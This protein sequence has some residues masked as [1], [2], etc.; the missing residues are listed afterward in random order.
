MARAP[1]DLARAV[2]LHELQRGYT[3][4]ALLGTIGVY[5]SITL[6]VQGVTGWLD[7]ASLGGWWGISLPWILLAAVVPQFF[8]LSRHFARASDVQRLPKSFW[9]Q[10]VLVLLWL[11]LLSWYS[12][13][14]LSAL[15]L[16]VLVGAVFNDVS[17]LFDARGLYAAYGLFW[18]IQVAILLVVDLC[19]GPGLLQRYA[20]N[21]V[22]VALTLAT[23]LCLMVLLSAIIRVVGKN[24]RE[25]EEGYRAAGRLQSELR[26]METERGVLARSCDFLLHGLSATRFSHDVASP[27]SVLK[28]TSHAV[29]SALDRLGGDEVV[30]LRRLMERMDAAIHRLEG[31]TRT[32]A[33][34][35]RQPGKLQ[36]ISAVELI[37]QAVAYARQA[38]EQH[39]LTSL[40]A[41]V[42]AS[43]AD[44]F[45]SAEHTSAL[46][47]IISNS[48]LEGSLA[49]SIKGEPIDDLFYQIQLRD[50]ALQGQ[51]RVLALQTI[52][53]SM[54]LDN[55][56]R[57]PEQ[58]R[59]TQY[60]GYGIGLLMT[61][62]LIVRSGG[63]LSVHAPADGPGICFSVILPR[64]DPGEI[65]IDRNHP[66]R[67]GLEAPSGLA[68]PFI[69]HLPSS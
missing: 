9:L 65:P 42:Q 34:S 12:T 18:P 44:V 41:T 23:E 46:A 25:K 31:M 55:S 39:Q 54:A 56:M 43:A 36:S 6:L 4:P 26:A 58:R 3:K 53:Q 35:L 22:R 67:L 20:E 10:Q 52:E 16:F 32:M 40:S 59:R 17:Y 66:E 27:L 2:K 69:S 11:A 28:V 45:V 50:W 14:A 62:V 24:Q 64:R 1:G 7:A 30:E 61:R 37:E 29:G 33:R 63:W 19:G 8:Q 47:S 5:V 21:D 51:E 68:A 60:E 48:V 15:L 49:P 13:P 57:A 38:L